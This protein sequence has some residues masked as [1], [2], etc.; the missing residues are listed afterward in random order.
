M[1]SSNFGHLEGIAF[2]LQQQSWQVSGASAGL[3]ILQ[4]SSLDLSPTTTSTPLCT[5]NNRREADGAVC[6]GAHV[7]L[8]CTLLGEAVWVDR[9]GK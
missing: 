3:K 8:M 5:Y 4:T 6:G 9:G 1:C 2:V 7:D